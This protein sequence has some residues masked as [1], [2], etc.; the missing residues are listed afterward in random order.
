MKFA[1]KVNMF[2]VLS[3]KNR[4]CKLYSKKY[5]PQQNIKFVHFEF[6]KL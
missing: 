1:E 4:I 3:L 5:S 2:K 6:K